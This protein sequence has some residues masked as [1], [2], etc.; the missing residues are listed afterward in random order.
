MRHPRDER[1]GKQT[2]FGREP[3]CMHPVMERRGVSGFLARITFVTFV[4]F[5]TL[6]WSH[7]ENLF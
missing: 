2:G 7:H 6:C 1:Q 3:V 5:V 4:T